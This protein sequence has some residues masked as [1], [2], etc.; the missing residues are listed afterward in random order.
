LT[1]PHGQ[2]GKG[3]FAPNFAICP[4]KFLSA[5]KIFTSSLNSYV[6]SRR[7][8]RPKTLFITACFLILHA[9][10]AQAVH[11]QTEPPPP[12]KTLRVA[13]R[14]IEPLVVQRDK[15]LT[16]F[17]IDLWNEVARRAG[18][19]YEY[20]MTDTVKAMLDSVEAG[21]AEAAIAAV[22]M[23]PE[24]EARFDFSHMY[25][26]SGLQ[27]MTPI[28]R[29]S[30]LD[31]LRSITWAD[32]LGP[33][34]L[35]ALLV[36]IIAHVIWLIERGRNPEFPKDY[37]RG[38]GEGIW[39]AVVTVVTVGYGDRTPKR[40]L[41]RIVAMGWMFAGIFLIAQLTATITSQMTVNSLQGQIKGLSD[42]P[43]KRVVTVA[44]TT[45]DQYL[46]ANAIAHSTVPQIGDAYAQIEAGQMDAVVF[47][48][49]VLNYYAST[50][51]KGK[52]RMAGEMFKPEPYGIALQRGSPYRE[53]INRAILELFTDGTYQQ[54]TQ[55]WFGTS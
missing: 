32:V 37:F 3:G 10:F 20:V 4:D 13:T 50:Q 39:W 18:L 17:S 43:G 40:T 6:E 15:E 48:A 35:V 34:A 8:A 41:G 46:S 52:V 16:G 33:V 2:F 11:A 22:S 47:D 29:T 42:L 27:I 21:N 7:M 31:S 45:A 12:D 30:W 14:I 49:P 38:V 23:T 36:V 9:I 25:L 55:K 51:G 26:Q 24:R 54:L 44:N 5:A 1:V 28:Q 53:A 19:R